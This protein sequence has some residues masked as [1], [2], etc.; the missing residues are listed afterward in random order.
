MLKISC[1]FYNVNYSGT[2]EQ[3]LNSLYIVFYVVFYV[4]SIYLCHV[5]MGQIGL[6]TIS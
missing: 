1:I 4:Y 3:P 6:L 2:Q 5:L